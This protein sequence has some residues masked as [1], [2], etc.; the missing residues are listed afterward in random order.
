MCRARNRGAT[1]CAQNA[2]TAPD[3]L[4]LALSP[5]VE[6]PLFGSV[7]TIGL[8]RVENESRC[9]SGVQCVWA[10]NAA[11]IA[12]LRFGKG[13]TTPY[14]LNTNVQ[15]RLITVSGYQIRLDSLS[16]YPRADRPTTPADYRAYVTVLK[17]GA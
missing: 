1:A 17:P 2:P 13:P 9:P 10:G 3:S 6:Q 8:S 7:A 16:P 12:G 14:T 5:G 11:V 15:P 4:A